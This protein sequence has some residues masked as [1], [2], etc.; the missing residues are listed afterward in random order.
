MDSQNAETPVNFGHLV[1]R[2]LGHR[3]PQDRLEKHKSQLTL[4]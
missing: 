1:N 4:C 3:L 2:K